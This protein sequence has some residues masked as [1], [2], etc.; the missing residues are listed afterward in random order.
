MEE[1][2]A[3]IVV[4]VQPNASQSQVMRGKDGVWHIRVAAPAVKGKANQELIKFLS[5]ILRVS[6]SHLT[7]EKGMTSK[8]KVIVING[9]NQNQ[10]VRQMTRQQEGNHVSKSH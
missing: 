9:L 5:G 7:V 10:V 3:R 8:E 6:K 4:R 1:E 2:S